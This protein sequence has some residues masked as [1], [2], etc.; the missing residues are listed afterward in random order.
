MTAAE[1]RTPAEVARAAFDAVIAKDLDRIVAAG[2]PDYVDDFVPVGLFRGRDAVRGFFR[3]MFAAFP[4]FEMTL[5]RIVAG[6][7]SAAVQWHL[8][9]TFTGGPFLGIEPTGRRI[10]V[11]GVDVMEIAD[12]LIQHNTIYYDGASFARQVGLLPAQGSRGD[13]ALISAFNLASK[14]RRATAQRAS[15]AAR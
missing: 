13:R 6:D 7:S 15:R 11:R 14:L 2:A 10:E 9:A 5:D 8:S 12:G 3:E 1:P 4:D